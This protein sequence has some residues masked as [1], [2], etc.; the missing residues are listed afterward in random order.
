MTTKRRRVPATEARQRFSELLRE[1]RE[2]DRRIV[3]DKGGV[4]VAAIVP[5]SVLERAEREDDERAARGA[6]LDRMRTSFRDQTTE[7]IETEAAKALRKVRRAR[8]KSG[9]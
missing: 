4:P 1:V 5:L 8:R 6:L 9:R 2:D 7:R 3:V